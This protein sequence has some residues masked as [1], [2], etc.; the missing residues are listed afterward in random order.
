[1]IGPSDLSRSLGIP[2]QFRH[3]EFD[4]A[5]RTILRKAREHNVGAGIHFWEGIDQEIAW[6]R[7]GANLIMHSA[8]IT[9]IK[10]HLKCELDQL[11]SA[12]GGS[13]RPAGEQETPAV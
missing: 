8:D 4:R 1:L 12:L 6:S 13:I 5:V 9:L 11:R 7:A 2:A 3:P 10:Q